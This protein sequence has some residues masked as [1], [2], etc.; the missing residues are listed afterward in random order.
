MIGLPIRAGPRR[1]ND[2]SLAQVYQK[3]QIVSVFS[4][5]PLPLHP[6]HGGVPSNKKAC[7][8]VA[9]SSQYLE[10]NKASFIKHYQP[11]ELG[12]WFPW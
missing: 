9:P 2:L 5:S 8:L 10:L 11:W 6:L 12:R 3:G 4:R 7:G 1:V